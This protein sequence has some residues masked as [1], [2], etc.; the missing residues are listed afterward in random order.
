MKQKNKMVDLGMTLGT[1]A[2]NML[3]NAL[4]GRGVIEGG[5]RTIRAAKNF[6]CHL[7]L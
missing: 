7:I 4:S 3:G 1:L 5:G 2:A 6:Q